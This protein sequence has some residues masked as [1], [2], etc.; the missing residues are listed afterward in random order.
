MEN[1]LKMKKETTRK[2]IP[3]LLLILDGWGIREEKKGNPIINTDTPFYDSL[4]VKYPNTSLF[5][6]G[7]YVGLP[8]GQV[9]NSE[10]GHT[11]I[12]AGRL[13]EQD[14]VR[15]TRSIED[16]TFFRNPAIDQAIKK[17]TQACIS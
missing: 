16:E 2:N 8:E 6:H 3:L 12:G 11:N 13:I 1:I 5:A 17:I 14:V 7:K 9:G 15:I 10:A 4:I